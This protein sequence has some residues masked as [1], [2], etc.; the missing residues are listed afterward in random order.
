MAGKMVETMGIE[1]SGVP[2]DSTG[3]A[4]TGDRYN[5][6][7][8]GKITFIIAQ[9]AWG[10]GT[11]AVTLQQ[12]TAA[13]AGTSKALSF[14]KRWTKVAITGSAFT[15]VA[16]VSDT[17]TLPAT[18]NTMNV[19]E[20]DA[21]QLDQE[22]GYVFASV[23]IASPGVSLSLVSVLAVLGDVRYA[24]APSQLPDPKV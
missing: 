5:L 16:V 19:L 22:N 13:T 20:V 18:A 4:Q 21:E 12:H 11:P 1:V 14:T 8:Y 15:E 6:K 10:A 23:N 24:S 3:A 7:Y 17:F 9:G 2:V